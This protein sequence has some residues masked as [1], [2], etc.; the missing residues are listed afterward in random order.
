MYADFTDAT[1]QIK[2]NGAKGREREAVALK[3][4]LEIYMPKTINVVHG[5]EIIDST[6]ARSSECDIALLDPGTPPLYAGETFQVV[7]AEWAHGII[8]VK[9]NLDSG[10]LRDSHK[11]IVQ[12]KS[13]RKVS[14]DY[15]WPGPQ[16]S[17]KT[18]GQVYNYFPLYGTVFAFTGINLETLASALW[19]LQKDTP[20][21]TWIDLVVILDQGLLMY[22]KPEITGGDSFQNRPGSPART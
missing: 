21:S 14:Y 10:E 17:L 13:L 11:K 22:S 20:V 15:S 3:R 6:G 4:Y 18:Y 19:E 8:E 9:S 12:A 16:L 2:H 1:S 7:P 5:A